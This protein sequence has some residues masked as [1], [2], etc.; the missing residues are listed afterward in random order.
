MTSAIMAPRDARNASLQ[1]TKSKDVR[2]PAKIPARVP[3]KSFLLLPLKMFLISPYFSP[4]M[5]LIESPKVR[6][7]IDA[8]AMSLSKSFMTSR[9]PIKKKIMPRPGNLWR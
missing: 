7:A 4:T 9:E 2:K 6:I 3:S 1:A 5:W 8:S